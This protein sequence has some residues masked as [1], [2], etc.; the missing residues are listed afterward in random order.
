MSGRDILSKL[1]ELLDE[2]DEIVLKNVII[3]VDDVDLEI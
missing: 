1:D 2:V 3:D